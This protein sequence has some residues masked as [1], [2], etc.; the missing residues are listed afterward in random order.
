MHCERQRDATHSS[1]LISQQLLHYWL[2]VYAVDT[3]LHNM[4][5][6]SPEHVLVRDFER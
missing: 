2:Q 4:L 5:M 1:S 3:V 6:Q